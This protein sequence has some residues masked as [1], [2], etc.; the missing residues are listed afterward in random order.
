MEGVTTN[1][2][3]KGVIFVTDKDI[4]NAILSDSNI[5]VASVDT[6]GS[7]L[8]SSYSF[9]MSKDTQVQIDKFN[10]YMDNHEEVNEMLNLFKDKYGNSTTESFS[11]IEKYWDK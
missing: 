6:D 2:E 4:I 8:G 1:A 7:A 5:I 3:G 9:Y 10:Y 11:I